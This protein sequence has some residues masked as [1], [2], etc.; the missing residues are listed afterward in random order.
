MPLRKNVQNP[1][2]ESQLQLA[3]QAIQRDATLSQQRAAAIYSVSQSTLSNRLARKLSQED[4]T[5]NSMKLLVTE[6]QT[7]VNYILDLNARGYPLHLPAI[8]DLADSLLATRHR[9]PISPN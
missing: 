1:L 5:P 6:E 3:I 4:S 2:K 9:D 8:K 7:I